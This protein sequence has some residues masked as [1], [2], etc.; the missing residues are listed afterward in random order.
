MFQYCYGKKIINRASI[1]VKRMQKVNE[2]SQE[3]AN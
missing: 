3:N 2:T 1:M